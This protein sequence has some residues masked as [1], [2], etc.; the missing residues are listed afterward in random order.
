FKFNKAEIYSQPSL[1][2]FLDLIDAGIIMYDIRIGSY[3]SGRNIGKAHDHGS[4]FRIKENDI[5]KLYGIKK[6]VE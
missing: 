6:L 3:S 4:G 5:C 1:A 2:R